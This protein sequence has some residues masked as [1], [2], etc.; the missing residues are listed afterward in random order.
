[1][2]SK[3]DYLYRPQSEELPF[4]T[5]RNRSDRASV[6][7]PMPAF[8]RSTPW[9][10]DFYDHESGEAMTRY[11]QAEDQR[12]VRDSPFTWQ[13]IDANKPYD[14]L[15]RNRFHGMIGDADHPPGTLLVDRDQ[16]AQTWNDAPPAP[17]GVN[18]P[19]YMYPMPFASYRGAWPK[20]TLTNYRQAPATSDSM[21]IA[22]NIGNHTVYSGGSAPATV[23]SGTFLGAKG[24][25][26]PGL[27]WYPVPKEDN[28]PDYVDWGDLNGESLFA[29]T[30][31]TDDWGDRVLY[32]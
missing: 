5:G 14:L 28:I 22:N 32:S 31:R 2:L 20:D 7:A 4:L 16:P 19:D 23:R 29:Y 3:P 30:Y 13:Q 11:W 9:I 24:E 25:V 8:S 1:M 15:N 21:W 12:S 6:Q 26:H 18:A 17:R 27:Q 10:N